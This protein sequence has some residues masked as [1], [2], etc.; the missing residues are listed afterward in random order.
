MTE[1]T[2][3]ATPR[4]R[5]RFIDRKPH[6]QPYRKSRAF[7]ATCRCHG[8]CLYCELGKQHQDRRDRQAA[9]EQI[10]EWEGE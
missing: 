1:Q 5:R 7:D 3:Q 6:R 8:G 10:A 9:A 2:E 4:A